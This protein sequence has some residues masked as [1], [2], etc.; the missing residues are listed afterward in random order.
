MKAAFY[1]RTGPAQ[2]V[3]QVGEVADPVPGPGEVRVKLRWSGVNPSDVKSRMGLRSRQLPF[4][5]IVPHSDG[6]G[7]V[8]NPWAQA[9]T[10][11]ASASACGSGTARG[12]VRS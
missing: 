8:E 7:E 3:L 9:W 5:R 12:S 4:A 6:M 1:E 10:A 2:E 11:I